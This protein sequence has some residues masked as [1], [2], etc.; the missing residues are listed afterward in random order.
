MENGHPLLAQWRG[1]QLQCGHG[2]EAVENKLTTAVERG[3]SQL[4]C[5]HGGEAVENVSCLVEGRGVPD[6]FNAATAVRPWRTPKTWD[7]P[8]NPPELQCGHGGEAVENGRA[9][10]AHRS[11]RQ[12]LQC[13]HGGEAVENYA[14]RGARGG[15]Y[16]ASMRPRR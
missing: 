12:R 4:Q 5:G 7:N 8:A 13:G 11:M 1:S 16:I 14:K 3:G 9:G 2:G 15:G 6:C 10:R